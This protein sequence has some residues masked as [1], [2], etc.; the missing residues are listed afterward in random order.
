VALPEGEKGVV[1]GQ[2][3]LVEGESGLRERGKEGRGLQRA[4]G[5]PAPLPNQRLVCPVSCRL[6]TGA[7]PVVVAARRP[8]SR[9]PVLPGDWRC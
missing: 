5:Q 7:S 1:C 4:Q 2:E 6:L 8:R 3:R 9:H